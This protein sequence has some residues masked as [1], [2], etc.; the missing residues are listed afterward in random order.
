MMIEPLSNLVSLFDRIDLAAYHH[1]LEYAKH[2][3]TE[4]RNIAD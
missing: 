3:D 4:H 2:S 1:D